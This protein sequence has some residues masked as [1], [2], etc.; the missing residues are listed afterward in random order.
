VSDLLDVRVIAAPEA[1]ALAVTRLA[2]VLDLDR[3]RGPYPSRKT[4][5]LVRYYLT[6]RLRTATTT[7]RGERR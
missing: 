7:E 2:E 3:P 6:A 4:P 1:A 5:G